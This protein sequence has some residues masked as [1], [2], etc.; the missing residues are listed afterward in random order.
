[1]KW[2]NDRGVSYWDEWVREDGT[3]GKSY[4]YQFRNF[5]GIDQIKL[6]TD[7]IVNDTMSRRIILS[8][9]N[10]N[11]L[12]DMAL[13]PCQYDFHFTCEPDI[14]LMNQYKVHL[15]AHMRSTDSF[16]GLPYDIIFDALFLSIIC[17]FCTSWKENK[18]YKAFV[19]GNIYMTC[20]NFHLYTNHVDAA[21]QYTKNVIDNM[22]GVINSNTKLN[23]A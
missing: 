8:L 20:D 10:P 11:D 16:L 6:I 21:K 5:S 7:R 17:N 12:K 19:P 3:I 13:E 9:W 1:M 4:G 15:H 22:Y 23:M 2:L 14:M 18:E